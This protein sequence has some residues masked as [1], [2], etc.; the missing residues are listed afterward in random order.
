[1]TVKINYSQNTL[2]TADIFR[3]KECLNFKPMAGTGMCRHQGMGK[4]C[5]APTIR[6][7]NNEQI[8]HECGPKFSD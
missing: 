1:M 5:E 3:E 2:C 7:K 6:R 8:L 4:T